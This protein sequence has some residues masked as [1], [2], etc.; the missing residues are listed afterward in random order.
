MTRLEA[1]LQTSAGT[2]TAMPAAPVI[3][4]D[5]PVPDEGPL[6]A[7]V[8]VLGESLGWEEHEQRKNFVGR[9][10]KK[11]RN[12]MRLAGVIPEKCRILNVYPFYPAGGSIDNVDDPVVRR[13][14]KDALERIRLCTRAE[15]VVCI[16]NVALEALTGLRDITRRRGS[17]YEWEGKKVVG[18]IHPAAVLRRPQ[19]EKQGRLDWERVKL[20][21]TPHETHYEYCG[22][23]HRIERKHYTPY[24]CDRETLLTYLRV[25]GD[26]SQKPQIVMAIDIETPKV[27]GKRQIVCVS[28]SYDETFS[29]VLPFEEFKGA[30]RQLCESP[31]VKLGHNFV[32]YDRWWLRREGIEVRGEIRD[33]MCLHHCLDPA[34][35]HALEYLTSIYTWE[36]FYKDEGKGHDIAL[37]EKD[38]N[39]YYSY[40]GLD[41][42]VTLEIHNRLWPELERRG[43]VD[44]YRRHYEALYDPILDLM[45]QGVRIDHAVR[46]DTL[47]LLL[48]EARTARDRLGTLNG[49]PLFTLGTQRDQRLFESLCC[50]DTEGFDALVRKY[51]QDA[52]TTSLERIESK[53]VSNAHLKRLLYDKLGLPLQTRRRQGGEETATADA[54]A[55]RKLRLAHLDRPDVCEVI[56]LAMHHNKSMKLASFLYPNT[57]DEDGMFRFTLKLNTEAARLAS[58]KAPNGNG[59]NSQNTARDDPTGRYPSIRRCMLPDPGCVLLEADLSQVEG[60]VCFIYTKDSEL[61]R[62]ARLRSMEFD[63]HKFVASL[64]FGV[65]VEAV[66]RPQRQVSK[67][68]GHGAQR[69]MQGLRMSETL[70]KDGF[71]F[72]EDECDAYIEQYHKAFP[73]IRLLHQ[74][75]RRE[76]R[77]KK[78]L[79]SSW[80]RIWDVRY[81]EMNDELFRKAYSCVFQTECADLTNQCGFVPLWLWLRQERMRSRILLQEHDALVCSCPVDEAYDVALFLKNHLEVERNYDGVS[82]S[83]PVE[84]AVGPNYG[85]KTEIRELPEREVFERIVRGVLD[86]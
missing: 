2:P 56:D 36:P 76:V 38:V 9:S 45:S 70:M 83:V 84:F 26:A 34:S 29:L 71:V 40:C 86:R 79:V 6:D 5:A 20:L 73:A 8:M 65:S 23:A 63:Q 35:A 58:A 85:E 64:V 7:R 37:I 60:R 10:G 3:N 44:F 41:S 72:T 75:I 27:Q 55:L 16:G 1:L 28:F 52:V 77:T 80:G 14:Q 18:I 15:V 13:W 21:T 78:R 51:G 25:F 61:V 22:C 69:D 43:M 17:V 49:S 32:S 46:Q 24:S 67:S 47:E 50:H 74:H 42:C 12:W 59:R 39:G 68:I 53:T 33:S 66:T 11:L 82:L 48:G 81:E 4:Y 19:Y 31:C 57:V 30:I 54:V 62:L